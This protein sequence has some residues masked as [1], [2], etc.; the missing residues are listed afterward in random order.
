M[1]KTGYEG[2][3]DKIRE[4]KITP[5]LEVVENKYA[6]KDYI[7][8]LSTNELTTVCPK[9]GLPDFAQLT[10]QY[11]PK[12]YLVEQ[13]ALKLYLN[14]YRSIGIFQEHATNKIFDDFI[15]TVKPRWAK[16]EVVWNIRG[17]IGVKVVREYMGSD[18]ERG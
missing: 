3:Q 18:L 11:K 14:G 8:E 16:I 10:I 4:L 9:T 12:E 5:A 15:I 7:V 6:D 2:K 13:K 17:G 1:A